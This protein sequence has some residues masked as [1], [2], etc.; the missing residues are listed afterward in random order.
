MAKK[1]VVSYAG[2]ALGT[3]QGK[4]EAVPTSETMSLPEQQFPLSLQAQ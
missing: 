4:K 3:D 2:L 1:S